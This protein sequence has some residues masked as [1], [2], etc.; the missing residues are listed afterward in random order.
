MSNPADILKEYLVSLGFDIDNSSY[1]RFKAILADVSREVEGHSA[2]WAKG[3]ASAATIIAGAL[4]SIATATAGLIDHVAQADLGYQKFALHMFMGARQAREMKIATDALGESLQDIAWIKELRGR[5]NTLLGEE[6]SMEAP[7]E[8][9]GAE[10]AYRHIRDIRFEWTRL[11]VEMTYGSRYIGFYLMKYLA[12]PAGN[13]QTALHRMNN[14]LENNMPIW[15]N[16]V[17]KFL[18]QIIEV[19]ESALRFAADIGR[20]FKGL[21]DSLDKG[22]KTILVIGALIEALLVSGPIGRAVMVI[23]GLLL[24]IDDFYAYL[25]GRKSSQ[26]LAPLW[27]ELIA[28]AQ[29]INNLFSQTDAVMGGFGDSLDKSGRHVSQL[30]ILMWQLGADVIR[31]TWALTAMSKAWNVVAL[32]MSGRFK[33]GWHLAQSI[34]ED[35]FKGTQ[36]VR[37]SNPFFRGLAATESGGN[38]NAVN[39]DTGAYGKYQIMPQNWAQWAKEAGLPANSAMTPANQELVTRTRITKYNL[40]FGGD[41]RLVAAAWYAGEGYA[42]S[43]QAGHPFYDPNKAQG[44]YPSVNDYIKRVTGQTWNM[45]YLSKAGGANIDNS[46]SVGDI[47]VSHSNASATDIG[48]AVKRAIQEHQAKQTALQ[49]RDLRG[50]HG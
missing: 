14:W 49:L 6:R 2:G 10:S 36:A 30:S 3:Y 47:H 35:F 21:W 38:Y 20:F 22:S 41:Q 17:A 15:T 23:S 11:K 1:Q 12:G 16:K 18:A 25:D 33:E 19:G 4:A 50:I 5:Y 8:A 45:P 31:V 27:Q 40:E 43:L 44:K 9:G 37:D 46:V 28:A 48:G 7:L 24:L 34:G 29:M 32:Y 39:K 26:T 42:K 13:I